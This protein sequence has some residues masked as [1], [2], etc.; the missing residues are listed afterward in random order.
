MSTEP[1]SS[2]NLPLLVAAL[3]IAE[4]TGSF[5]TAM[6]LAALKALVQSFGD[7]ALVGWL[8][9][10][11]LIVG[12]AVAAIIGCL[13]DLFG[14][15]RVL[16][17]SLMI[18]AVGSLISAFSSNFNILLAGRLLQGLTGAILPLC[19]GLVHEN[20]SAR[21]VPMGIGL[22][23]S[24]ASIGT[25]AGL[26]VGGFIVDQFGWHAIFLASAGLC[27]LSA[28]ATGCFV[29][30][31]PHR[32]TGQTVDWLS[33]LAFA[34]GVVLVLIYFNM[35]KAQGWISLPAL[36]AMAVGLLLIGWWWRAS[37]Q[38]PNPL[39]AVRSF[40]NRTIAIICAVTALVSMGA[41]QIT[42]YFSLLLQAPVWTVAG[43]G[44]SAT[45]AGLAKL[46]S[47]ISSVLAGPLS[48]WLT[49]RGGG[50][51]A[52]IIGGLI[53]LTGW[54][55]HFSIG[56]TSFAMVVGQLIVISFGTTMLFTVA[57]T[58]LAQVSPADRISE[59]SGLLTVIRQLFMGIGAQMVTMLLAA[60]IVQQQGES[61]PSAFA[62]DLACGAIILLCALA[63]GT[64]LAL[65]RMAPGTMPDRFQPS[66]TGELS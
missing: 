63:V 58:I 65:P 57:P 16:I 28:L 11:Y 12:A 55:L 51:M 39:I 50:R 10:G 54:L 34:P 18:A 46:P 20:L 40:G 29:P 4:V 8:I 53:T 14:R 15:R 23:I 32:H 30:V 36:S 38:S 27:S 13:G 56:A 26:V 62:Y 9:T 64:A 19:I 41:L 35:G 7:P 17:I 43:L 31:S 24:G 52:L 22:M 47:N 44:L 45:V 2:R 25:A 42:V 5:E 48:G 59:I 21:R 6:I 60:D 61:Y 1:A 49:G 3:W 66:P 33:G 37:L